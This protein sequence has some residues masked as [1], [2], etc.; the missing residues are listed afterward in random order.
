[1][2]KNLKYFIFAL[3]LTSALVFSINVI[4]QKTEDSFVFTAQ[5]IDIPEFSK[6]EIKPNILANSA[7]L[8]EVDQKN[9]SLIHFEK[10]KDAQLPIAS[11]TK[12][13]TALVVFENKDIYPLSLPIVLSEKTVSQIDASR[14]TI[15]EKG[16]ILSLETLL[17]ILLIESGN[18]AAY[19]IA[20][21]LGEKEF[22]T[23]MN[24]KAKELGMQDTFFINSSGLDNEYK[25]SFSTVKDLSILAQYIQ[26]NY[27]E[28]FQI[29]TK[30]TYHVFDINNDFYYFIPENTNRLLFEIPEII[31]GKTG[32]TPRAG[33]CLMVLFSH[34]E[35]NNYFI[36]IVLNSQDRFGDIRKIIQKIYNGY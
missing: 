6:L 22:I 15:L 19:V 27:P 29:S 4:S 23:T 17:N 9:N 25:Y 34:P 32:W 8:L 1:M 13:M 10:N 16:K 36:S 2:T 11:L 26:E 7:I 31:G 28:I 12:L 35:N 24:F 3:V 33:Q 18:G 5:I 30:E 21:T 14:Y 20:E